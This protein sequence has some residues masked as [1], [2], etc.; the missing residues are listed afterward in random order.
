MGKLPGADLGSDF[1]GLCTQCAHFLVLV[2]K[3]LI[4]E[5]L[6]QIHD[7]SCDAIMYLCLTKQRSILCMKNHILRVTLQSRKLPS[8]I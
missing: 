2:H 5:Y 1:V 3:T 6:S 8:P 7:C 4:L